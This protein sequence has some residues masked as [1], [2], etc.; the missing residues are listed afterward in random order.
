MLVQYYII[1]VH[2][3]SVATMFYIPVFTDLFKIPGDSE[4]PWHLFSFS[5]L[6]NIKN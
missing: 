3:F 1:L 6:I 4:K 2:H 5:N